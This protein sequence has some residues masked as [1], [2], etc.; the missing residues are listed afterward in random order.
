MNKLKFVLTA[1]LAIVSQAPLAHADDSNRPT[2]H[3]WGS[4][5][6]FLRQAYIPRNVPEKKASAPV[7]P[8]SVRKAVDARIQTLFDR[9]ADP[10]THLVTPASAQAAGAGFLAD[11]FA[12]MDG[13]GDGSLSFSEVKG[14]LDAQ[15]PIAQ[16]RQP[17]STEIQFIK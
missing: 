10:A 3:E 11:R 16:P 4:H 1:V 12:E 7:T 2:R 14:V 8:E 17:A 15:S 6:A 9:A 5:A 13:N